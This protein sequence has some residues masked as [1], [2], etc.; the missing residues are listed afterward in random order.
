[1]KL[2]VLLS[3]LPAISYAMKSQGDSV[4]FEGSGDAF[5]DYLDKSRSKASVAQVEANEE[6]YTISYEF[7]GTAK[8][9][10]RDDYNQISKLIYGN[11]TAHERQPDIDAQALAPKFCQIL[12]TCWGATMAFGSSTY[13]L[14][15]AGLGGLGEFLRRDNYEML[16]LLILNGILNYAVNLATTAI[17]RRMPAQ[18][19][20]VQNTNNNACW[21]ENK[22]EEVLDKVVSQNR[23]MFQQYID[24]KEIKEMQKNYLS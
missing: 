1:M 4:V 21:D 10:D 13:G 14:I 18:T 15:E 16:K 8:L 19:V 9:S 24:E 3:L 2:K 20:Y 12:D 7:Y 22:L 23:Q 11:T 17:E 6:P 5:N